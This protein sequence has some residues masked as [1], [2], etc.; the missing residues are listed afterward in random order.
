PIEALAQDLGSGAAECGDLEGVAVGEGAA[1]GVDR[2]VEAGADQVAD[3]GVVAVRQG[4]LRRT[5]RAEPG[6][7]GLDAAGQFGGFGVG[8]G[9]QQHVLAAQ[10][11][12]EPY[13]GSAV[14]GGCGVGS[15]DAAVP[16]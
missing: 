4:G 15:A 9:E 16:V 2:G 1:A 11:I 6:E 10:V 8:S 7:P 13:R 5:D 3:P 14:A 12:R